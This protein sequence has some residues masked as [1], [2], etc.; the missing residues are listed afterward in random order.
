MACA[1][2][3]F[4]L[5][6]ASPVLMSSL[7]TCTPVVGSVSEQNATSFYNVKKYFG[8]FVFKK[9]TKAFHQTCKRDGTSITGQVLTWNKAHLKDCSAL[10]HLEKDPPLDEVLSLRFYS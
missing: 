2:P 8:F 3:V 7:L 5:I 1:L 9:Q 4:K 6:H 10:N